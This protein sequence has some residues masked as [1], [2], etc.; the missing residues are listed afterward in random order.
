MPARRM[1][2]AALSTL[3]IAC[4]PFFPPATTTTDQ[5]ARP[6][7]A[8]QTVRVVR[9]DITSLLVYP[10]DLRP[11]ATTVVTSKVAGR[12]G[13]LTVE[14][15]SIV[16][17]G[18]VVAE[19]D[20]AAL[21]VQALQAQVALSGAEARLAGLRAGED[22]EARAEAEAMLRAARSRL[23]TLE[24]APTTDSILLLSQSLREAR[25][26]LAELEGDRPAAVAQAERRLLQARSRLDE[27]TAGPVASPTPRDLSSVDQVRG[28][29]RQAEYE[30][31]MARQPA[32]T[33]ELAA[34]RQQL[35][36]VED[37]LLLA[38]TAASPTDLDEARA[39]VEAAE[40][41]LRRTDVPVS[42]A[43]IQA[44]DSAVQYAWANLELARLQLREATIVAPLS[45]VVAEAHQMQGSSVVVGTP[46]VTI[47][48]PEYEMH[49][50][51]EERHL[52]Q[53]R[54]GLGVSVTVDAYPNES[55]T[56]TVRS[57]APSLDP[58]TRTVATRIDVADPRAKLKAGLFGQAAITGDL[59][60][61]AL[62]L[63]REAITSGP[64]PTVLQVVGGRARR[65]PVRLGLTDGRSV[66]VVQGL[67]EGMEVVGNPTGIGDGDL[68]R[69]EL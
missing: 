19:L 28:E 55:F 34:A 40:A 39:H 13:R 3:L 46:L 63:P 10:G 37:A 56:G 69:S 9:G 18:D 53:V 4:S 14:P 16:R 38:R 17:E 49:V 67:G 26:W 44:A 12:I 22:S 6:R 51:V 30:L 1:A 2:L 29:V 31:V 68:V 33:E 60:S 27:L 59:R 25:R 52:G 7:P 42:S 36:E 54:P 24:A 61:G 20:R 5:P 23:A 48:P 65:M 45:G 35:A 62:V 58:R 66:E 8:V 15:G 50:A 41:R 64:E 57:V 11:K 32:S 43:A 47:Q 21:E